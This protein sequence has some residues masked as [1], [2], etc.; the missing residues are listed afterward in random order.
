MFKKPVLSK[1]IGW[2]LI[3]LLLFLD[4]F[5][6]ILRGREGNPLW[7]PFVENF[8]IN[9]VWFLV[10]LV[11]FIFYFVVKVAGW[12]IQK[13]DKTPF[14]EELVLT[15]LVI[16]YGIFVIW[17]MAVDFLKFNL[18]TNFRLM[19]IPLTIVCLIYAIWAQRR[20]KITETEKK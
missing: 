8:G 7:K 15:T 16:G 10:P 3:T 19:I 18:I 4:A 12:L 11:L 14:A 5:L 13:T 20:L 9:V 17:I 1:K 2:I 6:D